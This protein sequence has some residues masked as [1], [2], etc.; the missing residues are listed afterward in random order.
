MARAVKIL[1]FLLLFFFFGCASQQLHKVEAPPLNPVPPAQMTIPTSQPPSIVQEY[2]SVQQPPSGS[3]WVEGNSSMF[4]D[5]KARKIG[6]ILTITVSEISK[7][8][9]SSMT[10][11]SREKTMNGNFKFNGLT[12]GNKTILNPVE[13]GGYEGTFGSGFTGAGST[14]KSDSMTAYMTATVVDILPNGNLLIRGSRWTK[15]N[16]EMQQIVL[17][18]VVRPND[19]SRNNAVLS[20]NIADAKI[21]FEGKGPLTQQ[22]KPGWLLQLFDLVSP[23]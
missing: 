2:K 19:I 9:K 21:F 8:S 13:F 22:Q 20:Q 5:I 6:D 11:T 12:A 15:V 17:E 14:S 3:L 23:F 16:N 18:G 4:Q 1:P 10:D 7:A